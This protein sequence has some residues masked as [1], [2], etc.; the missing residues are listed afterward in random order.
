MLD[1]V[2]FLEQ[3]ASPPR[4][5]SRSSP[6]RGAMQHPARGR[7][8]SQP[9]TQKHLYGAAMSRGRP[10]ASCSTRNNR[11]IPTPCPRG[12]G[13]TRVKHD[14]GC[15]P[16]G[17]CFGWMQACDAAVGAPGI[18]WPHLGPIGQQTQMSAEGKTSLDRWEDASTM[19]NSM[20]GQWRGRRDTCGDTESGGTGQ[21]YCYF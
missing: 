1:P 5:I 12:E 17:G 13:K 4:C 6:P 15:S 11:I 20:G 9:R 8:L 18:L 19:R 16:L 14:A 2:F 7:S 10:G 3:S 21:N